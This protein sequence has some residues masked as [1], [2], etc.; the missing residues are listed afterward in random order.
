MHSWHKNI[1]QL[2]SV[3][4]NLPLSYELMTAFSNMKHTYMLLVLAVYK[5][6]SLDFISYVN[7]HI[8]VIH[9]VEFY[10]WPANCPV[11][12]KTTVSL[13][14]QEMSSSELDI[15]SHYMTRIL[16]ET[17]KTWTYLI[18]KLLMSGDFNC[19]GWIGWDVFSVQQ[20]RA[21][22]DMMIVEHNIDNTQA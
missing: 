18:W 6:R 3:S 8:C 15:I 19:K 7:V 17:S 10:C 20:F 5:V 16:A 2:Y 22:Q 13:D 9:F 1:I 14:V 4:K 12:Y 21:V 11:N